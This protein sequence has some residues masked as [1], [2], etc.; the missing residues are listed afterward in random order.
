MFTTKLIYTSP[1]RSTYVLIRDFC[2]SFIMMM[3]VLFRRKN[4][5][6]F[7]VEI[8]GEEI[9]EI[10]LYCFSLAF[11]LLI[12]FYYLSRKKKQIGGL[13]MSEESFTI[14]IKK[15]TLSFNI[16]EITNFTIKT[17]YFI[18]NEELVG[19]Y[20]SYN[21]WLLFEYM[22]KKYVYQFIIDS[23][24]K[25]NQFKELVV[26]WKNNYSLTLTEEK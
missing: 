1:K 11:V 21:N 23:Y 15:D 8:F 2:L 4:V 19:L 24:Y 26:Y 10:I 16:K 22:N 3:V 5:E 9:A 12:V 17:T 14:Q 20:S 13:N 25:G 6:S 7:F 18:P